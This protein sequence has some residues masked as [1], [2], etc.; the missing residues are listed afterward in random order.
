MAEKNAMAVGHKITELLQAWRPDMDS[1]DVASALMHAMEWYSINV[2]GPGETKL[3]G[4][5]YELQEKV[6]ARMMAI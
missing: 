1:E 4:C 6:K 2:E 5:L 3:R